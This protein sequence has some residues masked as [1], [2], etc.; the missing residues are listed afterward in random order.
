MRRKDGRLDAFNFRPGRKIA[1]KYE[2][3]AHLGKGYEGEVYKVIEIRTGIPRAVKIF[4]PHRNV[5]DR[6]V[7]YYAKKLE[8]LRDCPIVTQYHHTEVIQFRRYPV[9]CLV[10]D[11]VEG[12][13]LT[14]FI[15]RQ[16]GKRLRPFEALHLLYP[17][18]VGLERIHDLREYHSDIHSDNV[19]VRRRGI[20]FD[21]KLVDFYNYGP[22]TAAKI[23]EDV[24][25]TVRLLY[26]ALGGRKYYAGLPPEIKAIC[27]GLRRDLIAHKFPTAGRLRAHLDSFAWQEA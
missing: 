20:F 18:V 12:R 25:Q 19:I 3:E 24:I 7:R 17:L 21:V 8:R 10:S 11:Y 9:T 26:D 4:Y 1:G 6:A 13:L 27:C 16:P 14:D 2:V 15:A 5:R 22:P 23:R